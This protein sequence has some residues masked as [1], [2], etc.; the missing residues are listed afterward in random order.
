MSLKKKIAGKTRNM[1]GWVRDLPDHRDAMYAGPPKIIRKIP[2]D[3]DLRPHCSKVENQEDL[4]SCSA[5]ASTSAM[6]FLYNRLKKPAV[7]FSRLFVY[8]ATRVWVEDVPAQEDSGCMIRNVMKALA[9]YGACHE[10]KWP[11]NV[12][13]YCDQP[14][15]I[16][17]NDALEHQILRYCRLS[18]LK[19]LKICLAEGYPITGGFMVPSSIDDPKT[20]ETGIVKYPK[21]NEN[22]V[23]GHAVLF[24]GFNDKT[25]L[26]AFQN[27]W[28]TSWGDKGFGYLP[29]D[30][31]DNG[32]ANDF[33]TIRSEEG[34]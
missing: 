25:K 22:F 1:W 33:W 32:L 8:Y 19:S 6:E 34:L 17:K 12:D 7:D 14:S 27:S 3:I 16:A 28:G 13:N 18:N 10:E 21:S 15:E 24:I 26:V 20:T 4:G 30:F 9:T 29:Y 5:N 11:Y 31:F 2:S 23:G